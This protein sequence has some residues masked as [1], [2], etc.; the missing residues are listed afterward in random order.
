MKGIFLFTFPFDDAIILFQMKRFCPGCVQRKL[1]MNAAPC[2]IC[3]RVNEVTPPRPRDSMNPL[4]RMVRALLRPLGRFVHAL[5]F[6]FCGFALWAMALHWILPFFG[7]VQNGLLLSGLMLGVIWTI[8][9]ATRASVWLFAPA[10]RQVKRPGGRGFLVLPACLAALWALN[11]FDV[12][13]RAAFIVSRSDLEDASRT[14]LR[15]PRIP[16]FV[17][18]RFGLY[19]AKEIEVDKQ[20]VRFRVTDNSFMSGTWAGFAK[21]PSG[22]AGNLSPISSENSGK[23]SYTHIAGDWYWWEQFVDGF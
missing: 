7:I 2:E 20:N 19:K 13:L 5:T 8:R 14:A 12:P 17:P 18:Q 10:T 23:P 21:C 22:C 16:I 15:P 6:I 1:Q 9:F 11:R 4:A 3:G